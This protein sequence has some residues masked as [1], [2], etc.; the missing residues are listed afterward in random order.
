MEHAVTTVIHVKQWNIRRWKLRVEQDDA[1]L[2]DLLNEMI[3]IGK[4]E[5]ENAE[6]TIPL[7]QF[8]SRLGWEPSME[9]NC[10][11]RHLR[12]KIKQVGIVIGQE[13]PKYLRGIVNAQK[14]LEEIL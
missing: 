13:L 1:V 6:K 11:E 12:W 2:T 9:Y 14:S 4:A 8:D 10:D 3:T 5:I 7:V